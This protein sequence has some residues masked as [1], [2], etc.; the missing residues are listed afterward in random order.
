MKLGDYG[1]RC[2]IYRQ[3][4]LLPY[5]DELRTNLSMTWPFDQNGYEHMLADLKRDF[6]TQYLQEVGLYIETVYHR[7]IDVVLKPN[8]C[9]VFSCGRHKNLAYGKN[10]PSYRHMKMLVESQA[11]Y[12]VPN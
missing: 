9:E 11:S 12:G 10:P 2:R 7:Y 6:S 4:Y 5:K 8:R 1:F 3:R